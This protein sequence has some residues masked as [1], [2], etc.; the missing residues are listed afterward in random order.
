MKTDYEHCVFEFVCIMVYVSYNNLSTIE[1]K[2]I[3]LCYL[4]T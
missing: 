3:N 2:M 4:M 1:Q